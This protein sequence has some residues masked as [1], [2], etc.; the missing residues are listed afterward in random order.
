MNQHGEHLADDALLIDQ[1]GR[2]AVVAAGLLPV[3]VGHDIKRRF[4]PELLE[5]PAM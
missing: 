5:E 4:G 2:R 1:V 3:Q